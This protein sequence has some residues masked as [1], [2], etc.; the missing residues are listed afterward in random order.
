MKFDQILENFNEEINSYKIKEIEKIEK[1]FSDFE[2]NN[3]VIDCIKNI[4]LNSPMEKAFLSYNTSRLFGKNGPIETYI[5]AEFL[6]YPIIFIDDMIDNHETR[7]GFRTIYSLCKDIYPEGSKEMTFAYSNILYNYLIERTYN[8]LGLEAVM[9]ISYC[10]NKTFIGG[11]FEHTSDSH[12]IEEIYRKKSYFMFS[13]LPFYIGCHSIKE[14]LNN[15]KI[16][17]ELSF[18]ISVLV[19]LKGDIKDIANSKKLHYIKNK[20]VL[21]KISKKYFNKME[22]ILSQIEDIYNKNAVDIFREYFNY[23]KNKITINLNKKIKI[24]LISSEYGCIDGGRGVSLERI[25]KNIS[26]KYDNIEFHIITTFGNKKI[27]RNENTVIY[28]VFDFHELYSNEKK[29]KKCIEFCIKLDKKYNF[30]IIHGFDIYPDSEISYNVSLSTKKPFICGARGFNALNSL[31]SRYE[32]IKENFKYSKKIIFVSKCL[33][34]IFN[35]K[36]GFNEKNIVIRNSV[37]CKN[38]E[39]KIIKNKKFTIGTI[40]NARKGGIE[41]LIKAFKLFN[42]K[43]PNTRLIFIKN[44]SK[45]KHKEDENIDQLLKESKLGKKI[46]I[47]SNIPHERI[48]DF[49]N[50]FDVFVLPSLIE[51]IPNALLEAMACGRPVI[52]SN[53][54]GIN[55]V[56]ENGVDGILIEPTVNGIYEKILYLYNNENKR[57]EL[58][59]NARK[60]VMTQF[61]PEKEAEMYYSVYSE[62]IK[63]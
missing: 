6:Q 44:I 31:S 20:D 46:K 58:G 61:T 53:I 38:L 37:E 56:I 21:K 55:E 24:L 2:V 40:S 42:D 27:E 32:I 34:D 5:I 33:K 14:N 18:C 25:T 57:K 15:N 45:I 11:L 13:F 29:R 8:L 52:A 36:I 22:S 35:E 51:G 4:L 49:I 60:K 63:M 16:L 23:L 47:L 10:Y 30:D 1:Y 26:K 43:N 9:M 39:N 19:N 54:S 3:R 7:N 17:E 28:R 12:D 59:E 48:Y 62:I 50:L 41:N